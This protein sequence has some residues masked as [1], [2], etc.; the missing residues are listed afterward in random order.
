MIPPPE[1]LPDSGGGSCDF[2]QR[3]LL[4]EL[5]H[6]GMAVSLDR[7]DS[8]DVHPR[9]KADIGHRL[10]RWAL[11]RDYGFDLLPSGPLFRSAEGKEGSVEVAFDYAEGLK[12]ADGD[13]IRGFELAGADCLFYPATATIQSNRVH[14]HSPK[15]PHPVHVRY[16]W[17]PFT[18][19]NLV[20]RDNLPA[21]TFRAEIGTG[22]PPQQQK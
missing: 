14:L 20:N 11:N 19:A 7:G 17:A 21:S 8:L 10:C 13:A 9:R 22:I 12:T 2:S 15:V 16:A 18:R 1:S 4:A 6:T 5:D 3:R